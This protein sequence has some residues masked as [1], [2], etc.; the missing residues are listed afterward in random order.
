MTNE[1]NINFILALYDKYLYDLQKVRKYQR[2]LH[3]Q[4][5]YPWFKKPWFEKYFIY[6]ALRYILK[7]FSYT[8]NV[9]KMDPQLDD[10]EAEITYLLIREFRPETV[11]EISPCGGWSTSWILNAI[12]DNDFGKLYSYDIVNYSTKLVPSDLS[13]NRWVFTKG[14]IKENIEKLPQKIDYLFMDSDHSATFT[15]W[16]IQNIFSNLKNGTTVSVHDVFHTAD[17]TGFDAEGGVII[18]WLK[19][20]KIEYFTASPAKEKVVYDKIMSI[21]NKLNIK[22]LIHYSQ[23]TNPM[24]FFI[25][26]K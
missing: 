24:I 18:D 16:Y 8:Q 1:L 11:V 13:K 15:H 4:K 23:G 19:Q 12:K 17:P 22:K 25:F 2:K 3:Y 20:K 6:R 26:K 9:V 5:G 7:N 10:V 21:K 14:D